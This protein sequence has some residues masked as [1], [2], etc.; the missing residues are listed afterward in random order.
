MLAPRVVA[1]G[2]S[3][4]PIDVT[5]PTSCL[6]WLAGGYT[7][8][9]PGVGQIASNGP[10]AAVCSWSLP[11][12]SGSEHI[13]LSF[14]MNSSV[15]NPGPNGPRV[16]TFFGLTTSAPVRIDT[17]LS[18]IFPNNTKTT[19]TTVDCC[20]LPA[21]LAFQSDQ[22]VN[23][24]APSSGVRIVK[25]FQQNFTGYANDNLFHSYSIDMDLASQTTTWTADGGA[26]SASDAGFTFSATQLVFY[27]RS[28]DDGNSMIAQI[29]NIVL[30]PAS[31]Q[32]PVLVP[33]ADKKL[34][35]FTS[36]NGT[37]IPQP[38]LGV[39]YDLS[40]N[41]SNPDT[42]THTYSISVQQDDSVSQKVGAPSWPDWESFLALPSQ[43]DANPTCTSP[44]ATPGTALCN[45]L[46]KEV[47]LEPGASTTVSFPF[48]N[49]WNW[50][51][52]VDWKTVIGV[53]LQTILTANA[54]GKIISIG[55]IIG[56]VGDTYFI[57]NEP[58]H[59]TVFA[60][61]KAFASFP[62]TMTVPFSKEFEYVESFIAS[63]PAGKVTFACVTG[64]A[65]P[66][67]LALQAGLIAYELYAYNA[68]AD[69]SSPDFT[70]V[71]VPSPI[72][73]TN[74]T[75]FVNLPAVSSAPPE[76]KALEGSLADAMSFQNATTISVG[77]YS[78]AQEAGS[79]FYRDAQLRAIANYA[80][81][82][83]RAIAAFQTQLSSID[84]QIPPLDV[85]T[86]QAANNYLRQNGLP[87]VERQILSGLG[88][89]E[90]IDGISTGLL[91]FNTTTLNVWPVDDS[92]QALQRVSISETNSWDRQATPPGEGIS[93][94]MFYTDGNGNQ[95]Q[96]DAQNNPKVEVVL[97]NGMVRSTNPGQVLAWVNL[98]NSGSEPLQSLNLNETLPLDWAVSPPWLPAVGAIHVYFAN[99]TSLSTNPEIIQPSIIAVS[100]SNPEV[101]RVAISNFNST[102]VGHQLM[103]GQSLLLSVKMSYR[104]GGTSQVLKSYPRIYPNT[105]T[106][107]AWLQQFY[108]GSE[109]VATDSASFKA[110]A[111]SQGGRVPDAPS[112]TIFGFQ[113]MVFYIVVGLAAVGAGVTSVIVLRRRMHTRTT[114]PS[115]SL[116][117]SES[118][119]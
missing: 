16:T 116:L 108:S 5:A 42:A 117:R 28:T 29:R 115:P 98:T 10:G 44:G 9:Q 78:G 50:I 35:H 1:E 66:F 118:E 94:L 36:W 88:L 68:A 12:L 84:Y 82:R 92:I 61:A 111:S 113:P 4:A 70:S 79:Q 101:V 109:V 20:F 103:P 11:N 89:S 80:T 6:D 34:V 40:L 23:P 91:A 74:G 67:A 7:N 81:A 43:W 72:R 76:W 31:P 63:V 114:G 75:V 57:F 73:L 45:S 30:N 105:A 86:V 119:P 52:P 24:D 100:K 32:G 99:T 55:D 18:P 22:W 3:S 37:R 107:A 15:P 17:D 33:F 41:I 26:A 90:L 38:F 71:I 110:V 21:F 104:L 106:V 2:T 60:G 85:S 27:A 97:A 59:F 51:P 8:P 46:P 65:C 64:F 83:D 95:L 93:E 87:P 49:K 56:Q 48:V 47:T 39:Q 62:H 14:E 13:G 19:T 112:L 77:R 25:I 102:A 54:H 53:V 69:P 96:T 58:F